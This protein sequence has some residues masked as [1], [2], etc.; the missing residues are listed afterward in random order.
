MINF[1]LYELRE[2]ISIQEEQGFKTIWTARNRYVLDIE[3]GDG[4]SYADRRILLLSYKHLLP[5]PLY[6]LNKRIENYSQL[7]KSKRRKFIDKDGKIKTWRPTTQYPVTCIKVDASWTTANGKT[8]L[9]AG[10]HKFIVSTGPAKY[11]QVVQVSNT[12]ALLDT[13]DEFRKPTRKKL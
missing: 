10:K 2:Y 8:C 7:I 6:P 3:L 11:I 5:Y 4:K 1:P 12:T 13:C 9:Q